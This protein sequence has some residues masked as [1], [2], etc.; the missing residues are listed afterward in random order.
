ME[1]A[2]SVLAPR[3]AFGAL[4]IAT[5]VAALLVWVAG[6]E[7]SPR[8]AAAASLALAS[9]LSAWLAWRDRPGP[10]GRFVRLGAIGALAASSAPVAWFF[11]PNAGFAAFLA[12]ALVTAG[13]LSGGS[14]DPLVRAAAWVGYAA[15]ALG[16]LA[17]FG[18]VLARALP[19]HSL[20]PV[21]VGDHP[22]WHHAMAHAFLQ[23][24]LLASLLAGRAIARR[25]AALLFALEGAARARAERDAL[26][27]EARAEYERTLDAAR[28]GVLS[29][30]G[31]GGYR[32]GEL[33]E[34]DDT[35]EVYEAER[36]DGA[37]V[38]VRIDVHAA[39][40][41]IREEPRTLEERVIARGALP[42]GELV[43][44]ARALA[45]TLDPLHARG[46]AHLTVSPA[47]IEWDGEAWRL[48]AAGAAQ[49]DYAA[50]E[51]LRGAAD[52]RA[53]VFAM[54]AT[55][56]FAGLGRALVGDAERGEPGR[57]DAP[58][59]SLAL[60]LARDPAA[61]PPSA[62]ALA[63]MLA[64]DVADTPRAPATTRAAQSPA[65]E[66]PATTPARDALDDA[67]RAKM[68]AFSVGISAV[69]AVGASL[70]L[71]VAREPLPL[72]VALVA[73]A[74]I[75]ASAWAYD[76]LI[77][78]RGGS[79]YWPWVLAAALSAGPAYSIGL[80]SG[81]AAVVALWLFAGGVF[82]DAPRRGARVRALAGVLAAHTAIFVAV[83]SGVLP[84][85]GNV[86]L[87]APGAPR[88][89]AALL[90]ALLMATYVLAFAAGHAIDR[91]H[92]A[93]AARADAAAREAARREV[94][95]AAARDELDLAR[96]AASGIF[97]GAALGGYDVGRLLGRGG[98]GEVY[99][100]VERASGQRVALK[101]VRGDR[102]EPWALELFRREATAMARVTS[103][104]VARVLAVG[105]GDGGPP[106]LAM[107]LVVGRSLA[108][109]LRE[110]ATL[111]LERA[112]RMVAELARG[113]A[114][115]HAAGVVHCDLKPA[116]VIFTDDGH[117]RLV[118]FGVSRAGG[119]GDA[120]DVV[121]GTPAYMAPEQCRRGEIGPRADLYALSLVIYRALVGRPAYVGTSPHVIAARAEREGP[122]DPRPA[123]SDDLACALRVGLAFDPADRY[124]SADELADAFEAAFDGALP[125]AVRERARALAS[126][127]SG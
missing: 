82:M 63:D 102:V 87:F 30:R 100:A 58:L 81:I 117:V 114:D 22:D 69:C 52:A 71:V 96:A 115:V 13:V 9:A 78:R 116:N 25:Y 119:E 57:L 33:R 15:L 24:I 43:A 86:P 77:V 3:E 80:H 42:L 110:R 83:A 65:A 85:A 94:E 51:Q 75:V 20:T 60:G 97:T 50:P 68:R 93:L 113:L 19:D 79:S 11:G 84:D 104:H 103:P 23:A 61:R 62:G 34:R 29:G 54:A 2:P 112:R 118:D 10:R 45:A 109:L 98:M 8:D 125:A 106:Y 28:R 49:P 105:D 59:A 27:A 6:R 4:A 41:V 64:R 40:T 35:S 66:S 67:Y 46:L 108:A 122:P 111:P 39:E 7:P 56:A 101:L 17:V 88:A 32:L 124:A 73:M 37:P 123:V 21:L 47:S 74:G 70:L 72:R 99:E 31:L 92:A 95:L 38:T 16:E 121:A 18:A 14:R 5:G 55:L 89:E 90:H 107:E 44:L 127:K 53:D 36:A 126:R 48:R 91:R 12:I 120:P 76:L 26:L 1:R